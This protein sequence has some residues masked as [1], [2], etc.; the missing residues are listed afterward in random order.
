MRSKYTWCIFVTSITTKAI[1]IMD[2]VSIILE[3]REKGYELSD[4]FS[5]TTKAG[6]SLVKRSVRFNT[7]KGWSSLEFVFES[8]LYLS[9]TE[10]MDSCSDDGLRAEYKDVNLSK[11]EVYGTPTIQNGR[12]GRY[13]AYNQHQA[14][15]YFREENVEILPKV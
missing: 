4:P 3:L 9:Y 6:V 2:A 10:K 8:E 15:K 5:H 11:K 7:N 14:L 1:R 12:I 13:S